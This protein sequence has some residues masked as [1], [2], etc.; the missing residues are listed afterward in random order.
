[1]SMRYLVRRPRPED[2][3]DLKKRV[4][5]LDEQLGAP[6]EH[7]RRTISLSFS[8]L[9]SAHYSFMTR[10]TGDSW[11]WICTGI[12]FDAENEEG[13][14]ALSDAYQIPRPAHL[15]GRTEAK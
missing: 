2:Y 12:E 7:L 3:S 1:M 14:F 5:N 9:R 4:T 6:A 13:L 8:A 15:V 10:K 11:I